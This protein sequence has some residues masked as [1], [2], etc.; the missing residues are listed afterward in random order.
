MCS[1][2]SAMVCCW[3]YALTQPV[4]VCAGMLA[5]AWSTIR[6]LPGRAYCD[7]SGREVR[8][9]L[10]LLACS[11]VCA[12]GFAPLTHPAQRQSYCS[13][14]AVK[15]VLEQCAQQAQLCSL[16]YSNV[17]PSSPQCT[18]QQQHIQAAYSIHAICNNCHT[19]RNSSG[20]SEIAC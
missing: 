2:C 20:S 8:R 15:S 18:R 7:T 6:A 19:L 4:C 5:R 14:P 10:G 16:N 9:Q 17:T 3:R 12:Q 13:Q 11:C 1:R